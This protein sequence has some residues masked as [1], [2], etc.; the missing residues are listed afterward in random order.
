MGTPVTSVQYPALAPPSIVRPCSRAHAAILMFRLLFVSLTTPAHGNLL[1]WA[2]A[3]RKVECEWRCGRRIFAE[4]HTGT[5]DLGGEANVGQTEHERSVTTASN[6]REVSRS[7]RS[8]AALATCR[9]LRRQDTKGR[10]HFVAGGPC[11]AVI[12]FCV[13]K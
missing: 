3:H 5:R 1:Y 6:V 13:L 4:H 2:T 8:P 10:S 7:A 9:R 11:P 12:S